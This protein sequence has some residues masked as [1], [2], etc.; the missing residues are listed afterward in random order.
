[1]TA[2]EP[3]YALTATVIV[4]CLFRIE[5]L[6]Q[7]IRDEIRKANALRPLPPEPAEKGKG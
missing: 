3:F 2:M 4:V 7:Q 6:L 5:E 1:M